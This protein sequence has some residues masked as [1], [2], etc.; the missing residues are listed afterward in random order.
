MKKTYS[1]LLLLL[2]TL[3]VFAGE[4]VNMGTAGAAVTLQNHYS[5]L[6]ASYSLDTTA[7]KSATVIADGS[8]HGN[9]GTITAGASSWFGNDFRGVANSALDFD[10]ANTK[11][12][13]G[14]DFIG[15][16]ACTIEAWIYLDG[17]GEGGV[18]SQLGRI[19]D[20]GNCKLTVNSDYLSPNNNLLFQ[21]ITGAETVARSAANSLSLNQWYH[22]VVTRTSANPALANLYINGVLSGTANQSSG[23]PTAGTTN[24]IIGNNNA[25]TLTFDGPIARVDIYNEVK[26]A[27]W[28]LEDFQLYKPA[29]IVGN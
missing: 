29:F 7:M 14:S 12:D 22:I 1:I 28:A 6:I 5:G 26:S 15:T 16:S 18:S 24:V 27:A 8:G 11:I 2:F 9:H 20:N 23:T 21:S 10:G 3:S 4:A 17:W 13:C 25:Q 19:L